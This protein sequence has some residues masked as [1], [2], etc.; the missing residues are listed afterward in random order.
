MSEND[1]EAAGRIKKGTCPTP[2][3]PVMRSVGRKWAL[4]RW[5]LGETVLREVTVSPGERVS[6]ESSCLT[7]E[8]EK[9]HSEVKFRKQETWLIDSEL[10][11][12]L[13]GAWGQRRGD[14]ESKEH[15]QRV[16]WRSMSRTHIPSV[17]DNLQRVTVHQHTA[18]RLKQRQNKN[19]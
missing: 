13:S 18:A 4:L 15:V 10:E 9:K 17:S 19:E 1:L 7:Q 16:A 11:G 12:D 8:R 2:L 3:G 14:S 5:A 6:S